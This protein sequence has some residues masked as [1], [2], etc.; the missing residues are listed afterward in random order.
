MKK[1]IH[2]T[3]IS[4]FIFSIFIMNAFAAS[5]ASIAPLSPPLV[6]YI[7]KFR[8]RIALHVLLN[9]KRWALT[10]IIHHNLYCIAKIP[11]M[12]QSR[13]CTNIIIST[14]FIVAVGADSRDLKRQKPLFSARLL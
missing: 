12:Q 6:L 13:I 14:T 7:P 9:W 11:H 2:S 5:A 3:I 1:L 8:I 10:K 4:L